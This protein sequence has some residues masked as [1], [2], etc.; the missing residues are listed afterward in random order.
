M[1]ISLSKSYALFRGQMY[2]EIFE[3]FLEEHCFKITQERRLVYDNALATD[4]HFDVDSFL[5][6]LIN[7]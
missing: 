2:L 5:V 4:D 7:R 3:Q 6:R 1:I